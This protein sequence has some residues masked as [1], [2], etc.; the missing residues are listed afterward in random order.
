VF[1]IAADRARAR[2]RIRDVTIGQIDSSHGEVLTGL[3]EG[4]AVVLNPPTTVSD[5]TKVAPR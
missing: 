4:D 2:T 3:Q 5:N 1:A